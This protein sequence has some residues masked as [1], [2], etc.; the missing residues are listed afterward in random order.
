MKV[1]HRTLCM[2][3]DLFIE[4][5]SSAVASYLFCAIG[6]VCRVGSAISKKK[7]FNGIANLASQSAVTNLTMLRTCL[8]PW[9]VWIV[10]GLL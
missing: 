5:I 1:G 3:E 2:G 7:S 6:T 8:E 10:L 9:L 4:N